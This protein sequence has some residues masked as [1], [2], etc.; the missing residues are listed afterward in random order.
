MRSLHEY[1]IT[2]NPVTTSSC[3]VRGFDE[4]C[5]A[6]F[7][8]PPANGDELKFVLHR[9]KLT[10]PVPLSKEILSRGGTSGLRMQVWVER[11]SDHP[12]M[13]H[14]ARHDVNHQQP[15]RACREV[16]RNGLRK[17]RS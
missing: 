2:I 6:S 14:G 16:E 1:P 12:R 9:K 15:D 8:S 17:M 4:S 3:M 13:I 5:T 10:I 11:M 7:S